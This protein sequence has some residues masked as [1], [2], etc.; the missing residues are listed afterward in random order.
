LWGVITN[1]NFRFTIYYL[2]DVFPT[3]GEVMGLINDMGGIWSKSGSKSGSFIDKA[4]NV[5]GKVTDTVNQITNV[6]TTAKEHKN[7]ITDYRKASV[8]LPKYYKAEDMEMVAT[9]EVVKAVDSDT[10]STGDNKTSKNQFVNDLLSGKAKDTFILKNIQ[11]SF[12]ERHQVIETF[13]EDFAVFLT[14]ER[15]K[16]FA[17]SGMLVNDAYRGWKSSFV[18]A[19]QELLRGSELAKRRRKVC[20][21]YDYVTVQGY[22]LEL[23]TNTQSSDDVD[24]P[25]SFQMLITDYEDLGIEMFSDHPI[26]GG[27]LGWSLESSALSRL[28]SGLLTSFVPG[29]EGS[30]FE[31][32]VGGLVDDLMNKFVSKKTNKKTSDRLSKGSDVYGSASKS[33]GTIS[34]LLGGSAFGAKA[35]TSSTKA[36]ATAALLN[37]ASDSV[38]GNFGDMVS[39]INNTNKQYSNA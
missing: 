19:Y 30:G 11:E 39:D 3:L 20:L 1:Y 31:P 15:P 17:Y 9:I 29:L 34:G 13:G 37:T 22:I 4:L 8:H 28:G 16:I 12:S 36:P 24:V 21:T 18:A 5:A 25:F 2:R 7:V 32:V 10:E 27:Q 33:A 23:V 38:S 14:G 26:Y 6:F 35:A